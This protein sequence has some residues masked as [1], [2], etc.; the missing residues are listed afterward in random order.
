M[1]EEKKLIYVAGHNIIIYNTDEASQTF[2][3][4]SENADEI[5]FITL[6]PSGR[7]LAYCERHAETRAQVT[8]YEIANRKKRK[9]LPEPEMENLTIKCK[10]FLGCAFSTTTEKQ[11]LVTLSG[12]GDWCAILWQWDQ[13]KMLA[14]IDLNVI[15]PVE[16]LTFQISLTL[17][18]SDM[19]CVVTGSNTYKFMKMEENLRSFKE[20]HS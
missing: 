11:H 14:K 16:S 5:N 13:F 2:I 10:E 1:H 17:I 9:T 7:Y 4:G 18:S 15:D 20:M 3:P 12:E 19:I 8:I 6:S